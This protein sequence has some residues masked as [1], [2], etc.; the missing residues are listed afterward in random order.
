MIALRELAVY[1]VESVLAGSL[2][3]TVVA[4]RLF[5][6]SRLRKRDTAAVVATLFALMVLA[7]SAGPQE[8]RRGVERAPARGS[9]RPRLPWR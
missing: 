3:L 7:M 1:L 6:A 9:A 5:L 4:A 8:R 2:A